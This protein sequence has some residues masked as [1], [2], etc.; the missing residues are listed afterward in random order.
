MNSKK[1]LLS[2]VILILST[3]VKADEAPREFVTQTLEPGAGTILRPSDWFYAEFHT[4]PNLRW[5]LSLEDTTGNKSYETGFS[6]S[7]IPNVSEH[8][9]RTA[10]QVVYGLL[11]AQKKGATRVIKTCNEQEQDIFTRVCLEI[12]KRDL[13]LLLTFFWDNKGMDLA[14]LTV[15]ST[16]KDQWETYAPTFDKMR[17]FELGDLRRFAVP[18]KPP[19]EFVTQ[20]LEPTEGTILRPKDWFYAQKHHGPTYMWTLSREDPLASKPYQTGLSIQTFSGLNANLG[21]SAEHYMLNLRDIRSKEATKVI[22][23]CEPKDQGPYTRTCLETEERGFH[24]RYTFFWGSHG[25]D[26]AVL[27]TAGAP[28]NLWETY[29]GTFDKMGDFELIGPKRLEK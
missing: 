7:I 19:A 3:L 13:H 21:H 29:A 26:I 11:D 28:L 25:E 15:A 16:T 24:V 20:V 2:V 22:S 27:V 23:S 14:V 10:R 17:A 6:L 4:G 18:D 1:A 9:G 8:E 12:E 5:V